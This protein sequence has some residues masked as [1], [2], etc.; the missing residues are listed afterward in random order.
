LNLVDGFVLYTTSVLGL[1]LIVLP[2]IAAR[3]AGVWSIMIWIMLACISYPMARVMSE[4]G[5]RYPSASGVTAFISYGLGKRVGLLTGLLY[6]TAIFVGA[7]ATA[8]FFSEYLTR[9]IPVWFKNSSAA[10]R[11][12]IHHD[13]GKNHGKSHPR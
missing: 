10:K 9:L 1:G 13:F 5:R 4:L 6:L 11:P 7:P 12:K 3:Q 2:S 8:L